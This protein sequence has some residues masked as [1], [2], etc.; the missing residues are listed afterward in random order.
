MW[1][2]K[3]REKL[4]KKKRTYLNAVGCR[5]V[6]NQ[7]FSNNCVFVAVNAHKVATTIMSTNL[8]KT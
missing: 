3:E 1:N 5:D 4:N 7:N 2:Q 8:M 6:P